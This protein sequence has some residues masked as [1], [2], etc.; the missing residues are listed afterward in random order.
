MATELTCFVNFF[1]WYACEMKKMYP[2]HNDKLERHRSHFIHLFLF[3]EIS[4]E[5]AFK[6]FQHEGLLLLGEEDFKQFKVYIKETISVKKTAA[7]TK[8]N[9][10]EMSRSEPESKRVTFSDYSGVT[11]QKIGKV[12]VVVGS[13]NPAFMVGDK[14][15]RINNV[16]IPETT[17]SKTFIAWMKSIHGAFSLTVERIKR[18]L[19]GSKISDVV[20]IPL[21]K[22][23]FVLKSEHVQNTEVALS[24]LSLSKS[25]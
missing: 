2:K 25:I 19:D 24:L 20:Q 4:K 16:L 7:A 17:D 18:N 22:R 1:N 9:A 8:R 10:D 11:M 14:V 21:R 13:M 12:F 23:T 15:T 5:E 6:S 3:R